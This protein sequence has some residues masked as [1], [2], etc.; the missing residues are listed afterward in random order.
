VLDLLAQRELIDRDRVE[1]AGETREGADVR[2]DRRSPV[3][4]D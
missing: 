1:P 2:V 4:L 3:I